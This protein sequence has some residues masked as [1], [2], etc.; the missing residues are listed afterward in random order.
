MESSKNNIREKWVVKREVRDSRVCTWSLEFEL[1]KAAI[2][3]YNKDYSYSKPY[4]Q[5]VFFYRSIQSNIYSA[6]S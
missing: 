1:E 3:S 5:S 2:I 4:A 6:W